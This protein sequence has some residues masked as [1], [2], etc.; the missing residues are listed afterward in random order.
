VPSCIT[1]PNTANTASHIVKPHHPTI[2][3]PSSTPGR[4]EIK[5]VKNKQPIRPTVEA[6]DHRDRT[7]LA[8]PSRSKYEVGEVDSSLF[9]LI[10]IYPCQPTVSYDRQGYGHDTAY[11]HAPSYYD[12]HYGTN[13]PHRV[14][15]PT[16]YAYG[17]YPDTT[18]TH[19]S[20]YQSV[21]NSTPYTPCTVCGITV[22]PPLYNQRDLAGV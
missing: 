20:G 18:T 21:D 5:P 8:H 7:R 12:T 6:V 1:R 16:S 11:T 2:T 13:G 10:L 9:T 22:K 15:Q 14:D 4:L 17:G 19:D 3:I